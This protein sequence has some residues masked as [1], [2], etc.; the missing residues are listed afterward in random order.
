V[1][2]WARDFSA[3]FG[4]RVTIVHAMSESQFPGTPGHDPNQARGAIGYLK[5]RLGVTGDLVIEEGEPAKAVLAA[6]A[7]VNADLLV[8]GRSASEGVM[9][10]LR[11]NAYSI[12]RESPCPVVS[13]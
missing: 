12:I 5:E 8:I 7:R 1:L 11:T 2:T 10:R 3:A 6:A 13:V 9:G 4:A